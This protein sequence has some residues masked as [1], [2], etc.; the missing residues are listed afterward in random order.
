M[1]YGAGRDALVTGTTLEGKVIALGVTGSI[2]AVEVV[3]L[4]HALRRRGAEV[5][6]VMT[7][8]AARIIHPDA[9][10]YATGRPAIT[11]ITGGVEHVEFCGE[12]GK[13]DL[14]LIAP[15]TA[16]T[17]AKIAVGIDDTPVT[18]FAT[19]AIGRGMPVIV[20]PAMHGSM[21]RHPAIAGHL[22]RLAGW[23]IDVVEPRLEEGKAKLAATE[24]LVLH[25]ERALLGRPLGGKRIVVTS[26][27]CAE[28]V[29]DV[30]ILTTRSTGRMGREMALQA[31]R[32]GADVTIVHNGELPC[33]RNVPVVSATEMREAVH[34][35]FR[36]RGADIYVSAAAISDFSPKRVKGKIRSG[37]PV[38]L[39]LEPLPK[40]LDEVM[41]SYHP[42]TIAFK[43]GRNEERAARALRNRGADIVVVNTPDAMGT[44]EAE[45][46]IISREGRRTAKG[47]KEEVAA[48]I[49]TAL[50]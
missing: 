43:L 47:S 22:E 38:T 50:L 7:P 20:A 4:A 5:Q 41:E 25:A 18:T 16:N 3:G 48:A 11:A 6:A 37:A 26:G 31:Y 14:L 40:L 28:P 35:E 24:S 39:D 19:T 42:V 13:A 1:A 44:D 15:C 23:G 45:V 34:R 30:R 32:L 29:D 46:T 17:L 12:G 2:A 21:Y 9:V 27:P 36:D 49:W 8:A 10:T 33:V